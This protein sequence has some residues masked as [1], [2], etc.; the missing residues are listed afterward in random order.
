MSETNC[1]F[2][3]GDQGQ[4]YEVQGHTRDGGAW[5]TV[6]WG[7]AEDGGSLAEGARLWPRYDDVR[8]IDRKETA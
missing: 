2:G 3:V 5:E 1:A 6:G 8:V 7:E 4:R